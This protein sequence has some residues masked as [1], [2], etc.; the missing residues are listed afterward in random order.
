MMPKSLALAKHWTNTSI[1]WRITVAGNSYPAFKLQ[2]TCFE[3]DFNDFDDLMWREVIKF[4]SG[5]LVGMWEKTC[6]SLSLSLSWS[7]L[8]GCVIHVCVYVCVFWHVYLTFYITPVAILR[9]EL[10][11]HWAL[12]SAKYRLLASWWC[13][14]PLDQAK[15][16]LD[17]VL[18]THFLA[19]DSKNI[20]FCVPST[21][22]KTFRLPQFSIISRAYWAVRINFPKRLLS[23]HLCSA[24]FC[25]KTQHVQQHKTSHETHK[26][27]FFIDFHCPFA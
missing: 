7:I 26:W 3:V 1:C 15:A 27:P 10:S 19:L 16:F 9:Q 25:F 20:G 11:G 17:W 8:Y 5:W 6:F 22:S 24:P 21:G 14:C 2:Q 23:S 4:T 18:N 13:T 12:G